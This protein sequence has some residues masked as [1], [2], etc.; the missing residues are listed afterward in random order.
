MLFLRLIPGH[1]CVEGAKGAGIPGRGDDTVFGEIEQFDWLSDTNDGACWFDET[2]ESSV[3]AGERTGTSTQFKGGSCHS[4]RPEGSVP[5][6]SWD[7]GAAAPS[8][9]KPE[10]KLGEP[11]RMGCMGDGPNCWY[12]KRL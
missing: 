10:T 6:K 5:G 2:C 8:V 7:P 3:A 4:L 1:S 9:P 12:E 11:G